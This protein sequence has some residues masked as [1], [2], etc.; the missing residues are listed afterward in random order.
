MNCLTTTKNMTDARRTHTHT[1]ALI[2]TELQNHHII[3]VWC[4]GITYHRYYIYL[5]R[6]KKKRETDKKSC[7]RAQL[8]TETQV[9]TLPVTKNERPSAAGKLTTNVF[10]LT[11]LRV[12]QFCL[13]R[14]SAASEGVLSVTSTPAETAL[15]LPPPLAS[16]LSHPH[17]YP[18]PVCHAVT[19]TSE[20][21]FS[22]PTGP[23]FMGR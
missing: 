11:T 23:S 10:V 17:H 1:H 22:L 9:Q 3:T 7:R 20:P 5:S 4:S 18:N 21:L 14:I 16:Q 13:R 6:V 12:A 19:H 2:N 15:S 8:V